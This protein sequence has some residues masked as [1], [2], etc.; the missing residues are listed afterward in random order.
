[1]LDE[2]KHWESMPPVKLAAQLKQRAF[3]KQSNEDLDRVIFQYFSHFHSKFQNLITIP[4]GD[5]LS[6]LAYFAEILSV[7]PVYQL[8]RCGLVV[9]N[10]C[11]CINLKR[12]SSLI[13][14]PP[15]SIIFAM[16]RADYL[17]LPLLPK[18]SLETLF[19]LGFI[20]SLDFLMITVAPA[21]PFFIHI[22]SHPMIVQPFPVE[23]LNLLIKIRQEQENAKEEL[24]N[25]RKQ[26]QEME[27]NSS[28]EKEEFSD[29]YESYSNYEN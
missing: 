29:E 3:M 17:A 26:S 16:N 7:D 11:I 14:V 23:I 19:Q 28:S 27:I 18:Y 1:M 24:I 5:E 15:K 4:I 21:D 6:L 10:E 25:Y 13:S 20:D 8:L 9:F 12:L 22:G 2:I